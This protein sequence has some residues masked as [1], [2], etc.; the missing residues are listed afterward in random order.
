MLSSPPQSWLL[1]LSGCTAVPNSRPW[2]AA[3]LSLVVAVT[4]LTSVRGGVGRGGE[5]GAGV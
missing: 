5:I 4:L 3:P 2:G 1:A